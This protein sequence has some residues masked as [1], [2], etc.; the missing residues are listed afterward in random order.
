MRKRAFHNAQTGMRES[1]QNNPP[2]PSPTDQEV[3]GRLNEAL[4]TKDHRALNS[5]AEKDKA[6]AEARY[7]ATPHRPGDE[8][9]DPKSIPGELETAFDYFMPRI[10]LAQIYLD[11]FCP[12]AGR[13]VDLMF[14]AMVDYDWWLANGKSPLTP[15]QDQVKVMEQISI[16]S[17]G[18]IHGFAPFCPLR[19]VAHRAG[20]GPNPEEITWSSLDFV[21][22]AVRNHGCVGVK[23]Y[24]P[25]GFAPYGNADFDIS[26][27]PPWNEAELATCAKYPLTPPLPHSDF[28]ARNKH[29][30]EWITN[31]KPIRY[32]SDGSEERLGVR[33]DQALDALY[34]WCQ[35]EGV[36]ILAHTN[37]TNGIDC[38]YQN[39]AM[40]QYWRPVLTRYP[41][42]RVSFGHMGGFD[43]YL[44]KKV[45]Q[46]QVP[47]S[48][49]GF[50]DLMDGASTAT[51]GVEPAY[52]HAY[53]DSAYDAVL[54][55]CKEEFTQR[56]TLAYNNPNFSRKFIFG[57]DWSLMVH[58]GRNDL[59]LKEYEILMKEFDSSHKGTGRKPSEAFF[60]WNAVEY[61]G[62]KQN[63]PARQRL[64]TFY[65]CHSMPKPVWAQKVDNGTTPPVPA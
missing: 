1:R 9:G 38:A 40:A 20:Y 47:A 50:M 14:A 43:D 59:Y 55:G 4:T 10:V 48:T 65:D 18:R 53:G 13:N 24:P 5:K 34:Q 11:T 41:G 26:T 51:N 33:L 8:C 54:L 36:P 27:A 3:D 32:A 15:L 22:D 2:S 49:L 42:L 61:T 37:T 19:E 21:Q 58:V 44:Q 56:L 35:A 62:L 23:L 12:S 25:M 17:G 52:L 45:R 29:L 64:N 30:P 46:I 60:G 57:S 39:L 28:W 7:A 31:Q 63:D 16:L 6:K